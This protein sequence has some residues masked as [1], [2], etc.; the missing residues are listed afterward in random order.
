MA[1]MIN[2]GKDPRSNPG[3]GPMKGGTPP[4]GTIIGPKERW[5]PGPIPQ[6]AARSEADTSVGGTVSKQYNTEM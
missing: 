6:R 3:N 5:N 4:G 1:K 2:D